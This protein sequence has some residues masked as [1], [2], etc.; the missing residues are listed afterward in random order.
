[1]GNTP[2]PGPAADVAADPSQVVASAWQDQALWS[3]VA[4]RIGDSIRRWRVVAAAAGLA[5][6]FLTILAG[7]MTG[8]EQSAKRM[9]L[10]TLGVLLL[11]LVPYLRQRLVSAERVL[12]WTTARNVSEQ[13]KEAI[14]RHL[15][16]VLP[17]EPLADGSAPPDPDGPA[18]LVRR[19]RSIKQAAADL[20]GVAAAARPAERQRK[21]QLSLDDYLAD[22]VE[23]QM[24]YYRTKGEAAGQTA[25]RLQT[26]EFALGIAAVLLGTLT[27]KEP[28][29][30]AAGA[31]AGTVFTTGTL[32]PLLAVVGAATAAVTG[33]IAG[34]RDAE[35]AAKYF[36]TYDLLKT[37]RDE[38]RVS[39]DPRDPANVRRF[40][41]A[42]ERAIASEY[43]GW[44]ADWNKAQ[45]KAPQA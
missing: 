1:M 40:A 5:G 23:G 35:T 16:G 32:L 25:R 34:A 10:T 36:A 37:L 38:W 7:T 42:V 26:L 14:Y 11:A 13:L 20:A 19:C 39:P 6:L 21:T 8:A 24:K 22:R 43:G 12:S 28:V 33:H 45:Q 2:E 29:P 41:D 44:V 30:D 3:D 4:T 15:M 31:A 9:G 27:G 18:N 17:P